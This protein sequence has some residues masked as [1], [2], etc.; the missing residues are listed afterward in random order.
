MSDLAE[1]KKKMGHAIKAHFS[2]LV[3]P[4]QVSKKVS[5]KMRLEAKLKSGARLVIACSEVRGGRLPG[6]YGMYWLFSLAGGFIYDA[7]DACGLSAAPNFSTPLIF[8]CTSHNLPSAS[9]F[10]VSPAAD[11]EM[12]AAEI[13]RDVQEQALPLIE[14]FESV[15]ERVLDHILERGPGLFRNP[16]TMCVIMMT[17]ARRKD[18]LDEIIQVASTARGF[19]D[20]K[21]PAEAQANVVEPLAKWFESRVSCRP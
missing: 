13:C 9:H 4:C 21:G 19:H 12:V 6:A 15:P 11:M 14:G 18:R 16:F 10:E 7:M 5:T 3:I 8:R 17:L 20:F 2:E 1:T